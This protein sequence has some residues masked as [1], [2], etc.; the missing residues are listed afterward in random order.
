[1]W[2]IAVHSIDAPAVLRTA[3]GQILEANQLA[4]ETLPALGDLRRNPF[5]TLD[6]LDGWRASPLGHDHAFSMVVCAAVKHQDADDDIRDHLLR[7]FFGTDGIMF[8]V[9]QANGVVIETNEEWINIL[10]H[11]RH[12]G[13]NFWDLIDV[14]GS[15]AAVEIGRELATRHRCRTSLRMVSFDGAMHDTEWSLSR[16][17]ANGLL[18]GVG[19]DVTAERSLTAE[20]E[21]MAYTDGLTGLANRAQLISV[22]DG[23][24]ER[25]ERPAVLFCDLD[26]FKVVNDSLGHRAGD[27]VLELLAARFNEICHASSRRSDDFL[28]GRLGG[29]EFVIVLG[30]ASLDYATRVAQQMIDAVDNPFNIFGRNVRI[31]MSVGVAFARPELEHGAE[32]LLG[33][34]D[35]AAYYAKDNHRGG[36]VTHDHALQTQLDRRFNVEAG[37]IRALETDS[38]EVHYQPLISVVDETAIGIEALVRWR[39]TDDVLHPPADFLDIAEEAGLIG[40]IGDRVLRVATSAAQHLR[41]NGT[42]VHVSV[43]ATAG[44]ISS[45]SFVE[46]VRQALGEAGLTPTALTIELTESA[47]LSNMTSTVPVIE[48]LRDLGVRIAIDDFGTGYS[49]LSY[50]QELPI[51]IVKI[52]RSFVNRMANDHVAYSVVSAVVALAQ[53]LELEVVVEGIETAEQA[54]IAAELGCDV[55][56]GFLYHE[57]LTIEALEVAL[58]EPIVRVLDQT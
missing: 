23:H 57:P 8:V 12:D 52:D 22:I 11:R 41:E 27:R 5:V 3:E 24:I 54:A 46:T 39:D 28:V 17:V 38:F 48:A 1:M 40:D 19:R 51:D 31:G 53:A 34:A 49:S 20:L 25:G 33:E 58:N 50:L 43:N 7:Q 18:F 6:E 14:E 30:N 29:D 21:R 37:L 9:C 56:Q 16:D 10:G 32:T 55:M 36:Y 44:Q 2:A 42:N 4:Q 47:M 26:R 13:L 45:P 15:D 35:T